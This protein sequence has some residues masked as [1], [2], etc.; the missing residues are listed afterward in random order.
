MPSISRARRRR[1]QRHFQPILTGTET[2][3][4]LPRAFGTFW[5]YEK[6]KKATA[7]DVFLCRFLDKSRSIVPFREQFE[8]IDTGTIMFTM[9]SL[10]EKK[11]SHVVAFVVAADS[12]AAQQ[13]NMGEYPARFQDRTDTYGVSTAFF[14]I[15]AL[16]STT[17]SFLSVTYFQ[18]ERRSWLARFFDLL[19]E[20]RGREHDAIGVEIFSYS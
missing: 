1:G 7:H 3:S 16:E 18:A 13:E 11:R 20:K 19:P 5:K 6:R 4:T 12:P 10:V 14:C 9:S 15:Y 17:A 8:T 2:Y